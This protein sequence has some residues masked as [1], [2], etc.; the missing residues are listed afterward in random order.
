[1]NLADKQRAFS[2]L[3]ARLILKADELGFQVALGEAYRPPETAKLYEQRG[4][5]ISNSLHTMKLAIDID[6][7][8]DGKYLSKSEDHKELGEWWELQASEGVF[9]KWG[10]RWGDGNHYSVSHL[11]RG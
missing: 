2:L 10:G 5:G 4:I 8:K 7:F 3:V 11:G 6:L 9:P 1:M